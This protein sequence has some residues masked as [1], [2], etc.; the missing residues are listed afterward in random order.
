MT[1]LS[2]AQPLSQSFLPRCIFCLHFY[3][4]LSVFL[5]QSHWDTLHL[6]LCLSCYLFHPFALTHC[7]TFSDCR[8]YNN[9]LAQSL[10]I[11]HTHKSSF[12]LSLFL[13]HSISLYQMHFYLIPFCPLYIVGIV[14][15]MREN[16]NEPSTASIGNKKMASLRVKKLR[17]FWNCDVTSVTRL[18]DFF[19]LWATIQSWWQQ[20]FYPNCPHC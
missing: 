7:K 15:T 17:T 16:W 14:G 20:L 19:A 3:F 2:K 12:P 4:Y 9:F 1:S 8:S 10:K 5:S 18:G 6:S 13:S 11:K